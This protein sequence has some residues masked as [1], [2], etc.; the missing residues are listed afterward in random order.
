MKSPPGTIG[1]SMFNGRLVLQEFCQPHR[2][3]ERL[4][5]TTSRY[6]MLSAL[7]FCYAALRNF[8]F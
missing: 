1:T 4:V 3:M 5:S 8:R 7:T 6:G 2:M